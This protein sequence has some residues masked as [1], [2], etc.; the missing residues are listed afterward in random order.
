[1][2]VSP[3]CPTVL[4]LQ[5]NL[6][7]HTHIHAERERESSSVSCLLCTP[8]P[9]QPGP[10]GSLAVTAP[11]TIAVRVKP[12]PQAPHCLDT[13]RMLEEGMRAEA[14]SESCPGLLSSL[15]HV[16]PLWPQPPP[17]LL[18]LPNSTQIF[19]KVLGHSCG[20]LDP[21]PGPHCPP[22]TLH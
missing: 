12:L 14:S 2:R 19:Q 13:C 10:S 16:L 1:V 17:L 4:Y 8:T 22:F 9:P 15:P 21:S 6:H 20:L 7:G 5:E 11:A 3:L 18:P